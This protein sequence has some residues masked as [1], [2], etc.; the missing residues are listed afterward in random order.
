M[1][2]KR[3]WRDT[4]AEINFKKV[5]IVLSLL[6]TIPLFYY[7][8]FEDDTGLF[9]SLALSFM[10]LWAVGIALICGLGVVAIVLQILSLIFDVT[11]PIWRWF[12]R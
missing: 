12:L 9:M 2:E 3:N 10:I 7:F 8:Y 4:I 11:K 6:I 1:K 5:F